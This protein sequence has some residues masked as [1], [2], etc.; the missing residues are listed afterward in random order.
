MVCKTDD[1]G[2]PQEDENGKYLYD[3]PKVSVLTY[4][5][6]EAVGVLNEK[7][8]FRQELQTTLHKSD[9]LMNNTGE[10]PDIMDI[11]KRDLLFRRDLE[12]NGIVGDQAVKDYLP[13]YMGKIKEA[14]KKEEGKLSKQKDKTFTEA[15]NGQL[16]LSE[17]QQR[18][19][20]D[21]QASVKGSKPS[22]GSTKQP[23]QQ[24]LPRR[25]QYRP[26]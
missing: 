1:N 11:K 22:I 25:R 20:K 14:I 16:R 5:A 2:R 9:V 21:R 23:Q 4:T 13:T 12:Q 26:S 3:E 15:T 6:R 18:I 17:S 19:L 24:D 8:K 7:D 10:Q